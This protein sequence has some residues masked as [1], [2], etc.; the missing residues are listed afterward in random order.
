[1][2]FLVQI[3]IKNDGSV[4]QGTSRFET[5]KEAVTQFH[6]A[7][8]SAMTKEDISKF[9]CVIL[10]ENGLPQKTEVYEVPAGLEADGIEPN[11]VE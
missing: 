2:Y 9:T 6:V 8:A 7:M 10:N 3:T 1:M 4:A 5:M 11:E